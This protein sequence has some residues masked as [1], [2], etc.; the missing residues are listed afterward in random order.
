MPGAAQAAA[1]GLKVARNL[2]TACARPRTARPPFVSSDACYIV[3]AAGDAGRYVAYL[4]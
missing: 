2:T 4:I 3:S 1:T